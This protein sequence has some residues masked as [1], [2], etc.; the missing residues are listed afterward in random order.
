LPASAFFVIEKTGA[1]Q[2]EIYLVYLPLFID[3]LP[4]L[5]YDASDKIRSTATSREILDGANCYDAGTTPTG[6]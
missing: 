2:R 5:H 4:S 1:Y 3:K 6:M